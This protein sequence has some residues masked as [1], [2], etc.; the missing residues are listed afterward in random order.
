MNLKK[1]KKLRKLFKDKFY[2]EKG[3]YTA[4]PDLRQGKKVKK[5]VYITNEGGIPMS[6]TV[7][8]VTVVNA[9][10]YKYRQAKK[11]YNA[12]KFKI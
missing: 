11:A 9:T 6:K 12:G 4:T 5:T 8:R 10:K 3:N 2:D 7:E 1:A